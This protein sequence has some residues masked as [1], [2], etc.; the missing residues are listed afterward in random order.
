MPEAGKRG[1]MFMKCIIF[2]CG[3]AV[4]LPENMERSFLEGKRKTE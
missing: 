4:G 3:S 1:E 2:N